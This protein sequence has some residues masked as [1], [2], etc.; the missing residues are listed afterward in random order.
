MSLGKEI[1]ALDDTT[2]RNTCMCVLSEGVGRYDVHIV[3]TDKTAAVLSAFDQHLLP[4][5]SMGV[6]FGTER[7]HFKTLA[8]VTELK[9]T[10]GPIHV[11][12][13]DPTNHPDSGKFPR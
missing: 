9:E 5:T 8:S 7:T 4:K 13:N 10:T 6:V 12:K 1:V 2:A 11:D 3:V